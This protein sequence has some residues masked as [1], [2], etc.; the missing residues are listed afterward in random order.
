MNNADQPLKDIRSTGDEAQ[1]WLEELESVPVPQAKE[2][3][4]KQPVAEP[5]TNLES[6]P[7]NNP[8]HPGLVLLTFAILLSPLILLVVNQSGSGDR[9]SLSPSRAS[10][11]YKPSCGSTTSASG[12]WWPVLGRADRSL[13]SIVRSR[14][15]GDAY[16]NMEG[17]LQVAS[18]GSWEEAEAFR[19]RIQDATSA[20]FRVG[21][22][23]LPGR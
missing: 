5:Y 12:Y 15:C 11:P 23:R 18:F 16:I 14:Y 17:A 13:L 21:E 9:S 3:L 20:S 8:A 2:S 4:P 7:K 1:R 22:S 10:L 19:S 6:D